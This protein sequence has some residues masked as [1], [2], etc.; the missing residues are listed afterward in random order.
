[1]EEEKPKEVKLLARGNS[2]EGSSPEPEGNRSRTPSIPPA[3]ESEA[4]D[5]VGKECYGIG[6]VNDKIRRLRASIE[7]TQVKIL[8]D[9]WR[10]D[11]LIRVRDRLQGKGAVLDSG[12]QRD[13]GRSRGSGSMDTSASEDLQGTGGVKHQQQGNLGTAAAAAAAPAPAAAAAA[14]GVPPPP[15]PGAGLPLVAHGVPRPPQPQPAARDVRLKTGGRSPW[16]TPVALG[17]TSPQDTAL[18][19]ELG[20]LL[21]STMT[22]AS[23]VSGSSGNCTIFVSGL[24]FGCPEAEWL[25]DMVTFGG[26]LVH[27]H[28]GVCGVKP[29]Y[30]MRSHGTMFSGQ[31]YIMWV[32]EHLAT[33]FRDA[34][35]GYVVGGRRV[36]AVISDKGNLRHEGSRSRTYGGLRVNADVWVMPSPL[37]EQHPSGRKYQAWGSSARWVLERLSSAGYPKLHAC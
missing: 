34:Y 13:K 28:Y 6:E 19:N 10:L 30:E 25:E 35:N 2:P 1:M 17:Y 33:T 16:L 8:H 7:A 9:Q 37:D 21:P 14:A 29:L 24:P 11:K 32:N 31:G 3:Y 22:N 5:D 18:L 26:L 27:G 20:T 12:K 36:S 15:P 4:S 23:R